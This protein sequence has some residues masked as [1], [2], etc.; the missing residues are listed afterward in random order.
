MVRINSTILPQGWIIST[1]G[2]VSD[3]PQYGWTTKANPQGGKIRLLRTTDI[4]SGKVEWSKVPFCTDEPEDIEKY[5]LKSGDILI[6]RAGSVGASYLVPKDVD[7]AVFA[8]YLI[9]FRAKGPTNRKYVYYYLKSPDYWGAIG[10]YKSGIAVP[11]VNASKL[12]QIPIPIAPITEQKRIV[13]EIEKQFSRLD[14]AIAGLKRAKANLKR[15]KAAVL[16]AAVEG[17][18]TEQWRKKHPDVEPA[19]KLLERILTERRKKWEKT[20]LTK[21]KSVG[22]KPT[23]DKWKAKYAEPVSANSNKLPGL[24]KGWRWATMDQLSTKITDGEHLSPKAQHSGIPLLSAKDVRD[25]G[26]SF[27]DAKY[28]SSHDAEKFRNRC[29]PEKNDILIVSRGATIGRACKVDTD[30]I[31]CLMGSVILVKGDRRLN[32]SYLLAALKSV[33]SHKRLLSVSGSTA[34]QAIYI[35]DIRTLPIPLPPLIEQQTISDELDATLSTAHE[36]ESIIEANLK[37][38]IRL[39]QSIL[40]KAFSGRL[41]PQIK[42]QSPN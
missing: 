21:M 15:Y 38:A 7:D 19:S 1:L 20:E 40:K 16:K 11:N 31:F 24:E 34:Q 13:G 2:D 17:K 26:V 27:E 12:A 3:K 9:R 10:A 28:V 14:E 42:R 6:S 36:I 22:K 35:R 30:R 29:D 5:L 37:R 32:S 4:T 18:L 33:S 23:D 39:R 8:S 41:V 25:S